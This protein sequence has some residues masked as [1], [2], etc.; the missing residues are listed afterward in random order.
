MAKL[1]KEQAVRMAQSNWWANMPAR[2]IAAF[3]LH[4]PLL[5]VPFDVFHDAVK[6]ALGRGVYTHEFAD[7]DALIAELIDDRPRPTLEEILDLIP[8]DKRI[9]IHGDE[10][11]ARREAER[12]E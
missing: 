7:R 8:A 5:C 4:E 10:P 6:L 12:S 2:D 3:Q 9:V 11:A 1:T